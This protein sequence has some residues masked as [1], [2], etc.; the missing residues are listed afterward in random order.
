MNPVHCFECVSIHASFQLAVH[1]NNNQRRKQD[2]T[3]KEEGGETDNKQNENTN[4]QRLESSIINDCQIF[5]WSK[6]K[7]QREHLT[8][9][10]V[11]T[12]RIYITGC[13]V[14]VVQCLHVNSV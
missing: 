10:Y 2:K 4:I 7:R 14:N 12:D 11:H 3:P 9:F 8:L 5:T 6:K 1:S 13:G